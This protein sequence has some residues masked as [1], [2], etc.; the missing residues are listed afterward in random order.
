M[1]FVILTAALS[2]MNAQLYVAT[3]MIF[4]L[5]R[6]GY[7]PAFLS[8][9]SSNGVPV[10]ALLLSS[11]GV[12]F[13]AITSV[14]MPGGSFILVMSIAMFG[15]LFGWL[16]IFA[17]HLRFRMACKRDGVTPAFRLPLFPIPTLLGLVMMVAVIVSTFFVPAF[18]MSVVT[19]VPMLVALM[20]T[21]A[22]LK[23]PDP[24]KLLAVE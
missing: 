1:N 7:A 19:G 23:K 4:S 22:L 17:T 6:S 11:L 13:A 20:V 21:Y 24:Q 2:A 10:R 5:S 8:S 14:M 12:A 18:R 3:R 16:M 15:A 9:V